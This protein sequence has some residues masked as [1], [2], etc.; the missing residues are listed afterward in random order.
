MAV[1]PP[2]KV[3]KVKGVESAAVQAFLR[4]Q[5]EEKRKKGKSTKSLLWESLIYSL[6]F[7][8]LF[9]GLANTAAHLFLEFMCRPDA[10]GKLELSKDWGH[11]LALLR[12][13]NIISCIK[14]CG[15]RLRKQLR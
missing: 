11:L 6:V 9:K 7:V 5:E 15:W 4:R 14:I 2:K 10:E 1:G 8:T 3:P 13:S 12:S